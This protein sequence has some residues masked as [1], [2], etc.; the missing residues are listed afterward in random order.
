MMLA[1]TP[2]S[3]GVAN[4]VPLPRKYV[5]STVFDGS[6]LTTPRVH[7]SGLM[8]PSAVGPR[9]EKPAITPLLSTAPAVSRLSPL[10]S[11][12]AISVCA[13]GPLLPAAFTTRMPL[14]AAISAASQVTGGW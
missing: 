8:R 2:A 7:R 13:A 9:D 1:H 6:Q 14:D 4:D 12:G 11:A 3:N 5:E 10:T